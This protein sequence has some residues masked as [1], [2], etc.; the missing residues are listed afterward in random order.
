MLANGIQVS[1]FNSLAGYELHER[2]FQN[3][4][5]LGPA[6]KRVRVGASQTVYELDPDLTADLSPLEKLVLADGQPSPLG[7]LVHG[8]TV[9]VYRD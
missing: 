3:V 1:G 5:G 7:G 6:I 2:A 9:T 4:R 8:N